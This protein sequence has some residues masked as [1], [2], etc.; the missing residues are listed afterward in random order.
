MDITLRLK[1]NGDTKLFL[2]PLVEDEPQKLEESCGEFI[3]VRSK[4]DLDNPYMRFTISNNGA[5]TVLEQ[6]EI[7]EDESFLREKLADLA[8]YIL[9]A[10]Q[11]NLRIFPCA[12]CSI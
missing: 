8:L 12:K 10:L 2:Q 5:I 9:E 7:D 11:S 1:D 4:E 6:R 3:L